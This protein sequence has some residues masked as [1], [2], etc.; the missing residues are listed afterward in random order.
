MSIGL[1][2]SILLAV[3][4]AGAVIAVTVLWMHR[5]FARRRR[6][7][8]RTTTT[9]AMAPEP[10]GRD[11][12]R[13]E[14]APAARATTPDDADLLPLFSHSQ[15]AVY[16]RDASDE[17]E[18][19]AL[20]AV[21]SDRA[22]QAPRLTAEHPAVRT[23]PAASGTYRPPATRTAGRR[24]VGATVRFS[25]PTDPSVG[26]LPGRLVVRSGPDAGQ[27][28][29]FAAIPAERETTVTLGSDEGPPFRHVQLCVADVAQR[30][31]ELTLREG[32]WWVRQLTDSAS[33]LVDDMALDRDDMV[34]LA[35]GT[36]MQVGSIVFRMEA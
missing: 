29:R 12:T 26:F 24:I 25:V 14:S 8:T 27:Q 30:H 7:A 32:R 36:R 21:R 16:T 34:P 22:A 35:T 10:A 23:S 33:T 18:T 15:G 28:L 17:N 9:H 4:T 5:P 1:V 13:R 6:G 20:I 2:M 31:A 3:L 11:A 19:A